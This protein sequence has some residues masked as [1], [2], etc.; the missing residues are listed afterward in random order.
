MAVLNVRCGEI[1]NICISLRVKQIVFTNGLSKGCRE[2]QKS[3]KT[4]V[5]LA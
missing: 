2:R 4:R 1:L 3:R 5:F